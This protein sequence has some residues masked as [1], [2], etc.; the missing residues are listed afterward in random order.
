MN[1]SPQ[2]QTTIKQWL[3][4]ATA[5]LSKSGIES[6]RLDA[7]ILLEDELRHDLS[8]ILAHD[9]TVLSEKQ[10]HSLEQELKQRTAHIPLAYI[11][12]FIEFYGREF[13]VNPH[14]L[15]PRPE[16]E[17][18]IEMFKGLN[19]PTPDN[20]P[21][22][23]ADIGTGSG[24]I[25]ITIKKEFPD[26]SVHLYDIDESALAVANSNGRLHKVRLHY[27]QG[28][29]LAS[30]MSISYSAILANL[31]Y[32]AHSATISPDATAEPK[33]ALF[34]DDDGYALIEELIPQAHASLLPGGYLLLESDPWQQERIIQAATQSGFNLIEQRKFHLS[35]ENRH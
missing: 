1:L 33:L 12:G 22:E 18:M 8:W 20:G 17:E 32:V 21:I 2:A 6:A 29:L 24:C 7:L 34:A 31:P 10:L 14:I 16:T 9:E 23:I 27:Y 19:L 35:F 30:K 5:T 3:A 28:N 25:G 26:L 4:G 15:I 13:I 11:R